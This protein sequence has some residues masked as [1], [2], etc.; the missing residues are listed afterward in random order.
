MMRA[1]LS[2]CRRL[3]CSDALLKQ[4][5]SHPCY[6]EGM[7]SSRVLPCSNLLCVWRASCS[8]G[9]VTAPWA[10]WFGHPSALPQGM[11]SRGLHGSR[12]RCP[13]ALEQ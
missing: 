4:E 2:D 3:P 1:L 7:M 11:V 9:C 8:Q 5:L 12:V 6:A 13:Q 10:A